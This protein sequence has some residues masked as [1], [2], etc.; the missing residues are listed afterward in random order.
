[1]FSVS[2]NLIFGFVFLISGEI[3]NVVVKG[4]KNYVFIFLFYSFIDYVIFCVSFVEFVD[5]GVDVIIVIINFLCV[6]FLYI[7]LNVCC[8]SKSYKL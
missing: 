8:N 1:M 2:F 6:N 7:C 4:N 5:V 3:E